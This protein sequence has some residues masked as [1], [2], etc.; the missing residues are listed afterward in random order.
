MGVAVFNGDA[1]TSDDADGIT[2]QNVPVVQIA[3]S[4]VVIST[5]ILSAKD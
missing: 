2:A 5:P 3:T 1:T 4:T